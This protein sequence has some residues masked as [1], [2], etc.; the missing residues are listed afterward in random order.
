MPGDRPSK[1]CSSC[2]RFFRSLPR[3]NPASAAASV[4]PASKA[5]SIARADTPVT[6]VTTAVSLRW[7]SS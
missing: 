7:V 1:A 4:F 3:A 2:A 5:S 6:V